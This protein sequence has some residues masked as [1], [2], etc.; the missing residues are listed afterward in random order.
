[1][2]LEAE[3]INTQ[4]Q[5]TALEL[6]EFY[7]DNYQ[8]TMK[9]LTFMIIVCA[10]LSAILAWIS[11]DRQQPPYYAA[12]ITGIVT[13]MHSLSEP[14]VTSKFI[15]QWSALTTRRIYNLTFSNFQAQL[16]QVKD[17]FT[18]EGWEKMMAAI[19]P[20]TSEITKSHLIVTSVV[21]GPVIIPVR[22]IVN[23]RFT[24][25]AQMKLLVT[26]TSA[27]Q[28]IKRTLLVTMTVQRVPTLNAP[29]GIQVIDFSSVSAN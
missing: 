23:G 3:K 26:Y 17:K 11:Y 6:N 19:T 28:E 8:R 27:N 4:A 7:R 20:L 9:L 24:W 2:V 18:Q 10:I 5:E 12:T 13:Q 1:M 22:M 29:Q 21:S 15:M 25:Q 14:V 16:N